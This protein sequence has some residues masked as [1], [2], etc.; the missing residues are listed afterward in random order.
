MYKRLLYI[1]FF[2]YPI[3]SIQAQIPSAKEVLQKTIAFH[4][5]ENL[6]YTSQI[7]LRLKGEYASGLVINT[8]VE[9]YMP[10]HDYVSRQERSERMLLSKIMGDSCYHEVNGSAEIRPEEKM[11][12]KL[13]CKNT[14]RMR[15]Y[16]IYLY[17]LPMK[18][19][20]KSAILDPKV[21][22]LELKGKKY[23]VLKV[24]Y[25]PEVGIDI[26]KFYINPQTY[27]MEAYQFY[28]D[29]ADQKGEMIFLEG[30]TEVGSMKLPKNRSWYD[31][32]KEKF[33]GTD[34]VESGEVIKNP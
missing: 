1:L 27:Q 24:S 2:C 10:S 21:E 29:E 31:W 20:D 15:N 3:S 22:E 25:S 19:Q 11:R 4:D 33:L 12:F 13:T 7:N 34:I 8:E 18:L 16:N 28:K 23:W 5:P 32:P 26:W 9:M 17:G 30:L 14:A 6:W